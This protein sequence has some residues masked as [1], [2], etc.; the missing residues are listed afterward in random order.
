MVIIVL[1]AEMMNTA[2]ESVVDMITEEY[3]Q[4][5]KAAKDIAAGAVLIT[6][7]GAIV[8]GYIILFPYLKNAFTYG[9]SAPH[10]APEN[11]AMIAL[12]ITIFVVIITKAY[13]GKGEPLQGGMPSGHAAVS[14]SIWTTVTLQSRV[15]LISLFVFGLAFAIS[16]SRISRGVHRTSE[17][18]VGAMLG[19]CI[20]YLLFMA[21]T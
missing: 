9:I 11:V 10:H 7:V 2:V 20:T 13:F 1:L 18:V 8:I 3:N 17:V 16:Y 5:A 14:F 21:F 4:Y 12:V 19:F 15:F 6:A